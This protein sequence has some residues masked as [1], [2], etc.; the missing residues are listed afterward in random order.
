MLVDYNSLL[1][2]I[3]LAGSCLSVAMFGIWLTSRR[4][5]FLLSWAVGVFLT[6]CNVFAYGEYV[7]SS[8]PSSAIVAITLL[9]LGMAVIYGAAVQ[10][11][12]SRFPLSRVARLSAL[13]LV[14]SLGPFLAGYDGLGFIVEN[15]AVAFFMF[16]AAREYWRCRDEAPVQIV[17]LTGLYA[18][19]GASFVLCAVALVANGDFVLG[20]APSGWAENVSL[21]VCIAGVTGIGA[22]SLALNQSRLARSHLR[23]AMTDPLTGLLN[24]RALFDLHGTGPLETTT[25]VIIFDLDEFKIINDK[26]GH[27]VGDETLE[28][29]ATVVRE[30]VRS[31][32]AAARIG[33]EEFALVL[34]NATPELANAVAER[35]RAIFAARPMATDRG[36]LLC[37]VSAGIALV[38]AG[39]Q[40]LDTALSLADRALYRAKSDGRNRVVQPEFRLAG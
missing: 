14:V 21:I 13:S 30:N 27:A 35:I 18:A 29:F 37:T 40:D 25:A 19:A 33:G 12:R 17:G 1:L 11:R 31:S 26:Y 8:N 16:A 36:P 3:G 6:V 32:D 10:F 23:D 4:E 39:T 15:L 2:A 5:G 28:R 22:L 34:P 38:E 9:V 7:R 24:R 20:H